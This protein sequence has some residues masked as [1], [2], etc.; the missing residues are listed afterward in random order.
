MTGFWRPLTLSLCVLVAGPAGAQQTCWPRAMAV[1]TLSERFAE[2]PVAEAI[3]LDGGYIIEVWASEAG[4][5]TVLITGVTGAGVDFR[6]VP[7]SPVK[8]DRL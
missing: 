8:G 3:S 5:M 2:R 6:L 1:E 7:V 4:T